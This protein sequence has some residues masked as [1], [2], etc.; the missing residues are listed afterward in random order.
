MEVDLGRIGHNARTLVDRL[1]GRGISVTGVTKAVLGAPE[2]ARVLVDAGVGSIGDSRIENLESMRL[3]G[4]EARMV[5]IRSPMI[6]QATRVVAAADRSFNTETDVLA[7]LSDAAV[8]LGTTHEVVLMVELGDLREGI[9]PGDLDAAVETALHLPGIRLVGLG[10]NLACRSGVVPDASKMAELSALTSHVEQAFGID[11]P[12]VSG[13]NSANLDASLGTDEIGRVNDLRLGESIL[14]GREPLHRRAIPGLHTDA[15]TFV[16]EVIE[17]K[18]KPT[19][20]WGEIAQSAFGEVSRAPDRGC[21]MQ[22]ILGIGRQDVDPD[23]LSP[24]P[25]IDILSASS[26]HLVIATPELLPIGSTVAFAPNYSALLRAMTSPFVTT[27]WKLTDERVS[28][29]AAASF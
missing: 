7:S 1:S 26:D 19:V 27:V 18:R 2:V 13:G 16:A 28:R 12:V 5:L 25:G 23:G 29:P 8:A 4:V 11:L 15:F 9:L 20:P 10:A 24:P 21:I 14:L 6:S 17:S 22:S 3:A